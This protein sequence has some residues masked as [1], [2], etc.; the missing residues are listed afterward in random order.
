MDRR[1]IIDLSKAVKMQRESRGQKFSYYKLAI[2]GLEPGDILDYYICEEES[3]LTAAKFIF[4]DPVIHC[5]T[6]EYP[7]PT[8]S[9]S[10]APVENVISI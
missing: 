10:F 2:P 9:C 1:Q 6:R 8:T 7:W 3:I 4:F 5:L